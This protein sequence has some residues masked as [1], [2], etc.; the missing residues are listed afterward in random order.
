MFTCGAQI[1]RPSGVTCGGYSATASAVSRKDGQSCL[2]AQHRSNWLPPAK[3]AGIMGDTLILD[4]KRAMPA[5]ATQRTIR[6]HPPLSALESLRAANWK[7]DTTG[8]KRIQG[9]N[10]WQLHLLIR[11]CRVWII[12]P[13]VG[14]TSS[15]SAGLLLF[16]QGGG[17]YSIDAMLGNNGAASIFVH[18]W[19][20]S[21]QLRP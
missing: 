13:R 5:I 9:R 10:L 15:C 6:L 19:S 17:R 8:V 20:D 4:C 3:T 14:P 2:L 1:I 16:I 12:P 21:G 18:D 7:V 11:F